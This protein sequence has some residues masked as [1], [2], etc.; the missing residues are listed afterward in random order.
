MGFQSYIV[1]LD[2]RVVYFDPN[3]FI[4]YHT[5]NAINIVWFFFQRDW[6]DINDGYLREEM[7]GN[8]SGLMCKEVYILADELEQKTNEFDFEDNQYIE[9]IT[10]EYT[11][12]ENISY[13]SSLHFFSRGCPRLKEV[14]I[15]IERF[16]GI[17]CSNYTYI[18]D[19]EKV[20]ESMMGPEITMKNEKPL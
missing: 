10:I 2:D 1:T 18:Y 13:C 16:S 11:M 9:K 17:H 4:V 8:G 5:L 6:R 20:L 3:E 15:P 7:N 19:L 12:N 14:K